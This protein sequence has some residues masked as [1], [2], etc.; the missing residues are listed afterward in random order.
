MYKKNQ[1]LHTTNLSWIMRL[2]GIK[3]EFVAKRVGCTPEY[4]RAISCCQ[5]DPSEQTLQAIA[6]VLNRPYEEVFGDVRPL[7]QIAIAVPEQNQT[8]PRV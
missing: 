3:A 4:I 8:Q 7:P 6:K 1:K 5:T 2:E